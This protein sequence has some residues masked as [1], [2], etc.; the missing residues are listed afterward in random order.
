[1]GFSKSSA[2]LTDYSPNFPALFSRYRLP[3]PNVTAHHLYAAMA[4]LCHVLRRSSNHPS[5]A[6][7]CVS[8]NRA[9]SGRV[10]AYGFVGLSDGIK[11]TLN[12]PNLVPSKPTGEQDR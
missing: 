2:R 10:Y 5:N 9:V 8:N 6:F 3:S 1:M 7:H 4:G 11:P 12:A